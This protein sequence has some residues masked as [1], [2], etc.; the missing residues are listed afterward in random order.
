MN[1]TPE[2]HDGKNARHH[3][4]H[5]STGGRR[6]RWLPVAPLIAGVAALVWLL[7]RTGTKPS[8]LSYPCQQAAFSTASLTLGAPLVLALLAARRRVM[9]VLRARAGVASAALAL[10]AVAGVWGLLRPARGGWPPPGPPLDYRARVFHVTDCPPAPVGERFPGLDNLLRLMGRE[11]LKFY[12]SATPSP[13][14]G[15]DGIIAADDVVVVKINY[16]WAERGGTNVDLLRGLLYRLVHHPDG[17]AGEVI[18]C[19]NAQFALT[20]NFDRAANNAEDPALSPRDV[21]EAFAAQGQRV[22]LVDWTPLRNTAVNEFSSAD[23]RSGYVVDAYNSQLQGRVSYPK[24]QSTYGTYVSLK[25]GIWQPGSATYDRAHF[26]FINLP[27]LKSHHAVYGATACV[28]HYM[29]VVTGNLSTNSHNAIARGILG[30]VMAE[31]Q[32]A[33]LNILDCI[34]INANPYSGPGTSYGG[35]TR[36]DELVAGTDPVAADIWAVKNILIPAFMANG[37]APPWPAPSADPD[38]PAGAFRNYLDRAMGYLLAGGYSVTNDLAQI[39]A[40]SWNGRGDLN[41]D[42]FVNNFDIDPFGLALVS[43]D[44]YAQ[45]YPG[46]DRMLADVNVDGRVDNFDIDPFVDC[47]VNGACP[48]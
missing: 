5:H 2:A 6:W 14:A 9:L 12:R 27:V 18:V 42:G 32:P 33:D 44:D 15:P 31:I 39:D 1:R 41:C 11:G 28:K 19:E 30:A 25:Y 10:F 47:L 3:Y 34:W 8:R 37:Y 38:N 35:A 43:P 36:R 29:G 24:F 7:L 26:K 4:A 46:C 13:T 17:F 40:F 45:Q 16:Q 23:L 22:S 48:P 21:V 20:E